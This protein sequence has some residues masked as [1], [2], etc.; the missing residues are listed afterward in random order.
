MSANYIVNN[1]RLRNLLERRNFSAVAGTVFTA[2]WS[3]IS[4]NPPSLQCLLFCDRGNHKSIRQQLQNN[5]P[6]ILYCDGVRTFYLLKH[7]ARLRGRMRIV[8]DLDDLMSRRMH[9][10]GAAKK[11]SLSLGYLHDKVP[12]WLSNVLALGTVSKVIACYEQAALARVEK[13]IG[14]WS[15]AVVLISQVEGNALEERYRRL[16]CKARVHVVPPPKEIIAPPQSYPNISRFFFIGTDALPQNKVTIE[17]ILD[18]W[19][20]I[21]PSTEIRRIFGRMVSNWPAIP[22]V[23]F[24]GY[25][26]SLQDVYVEGAVLFAPG[27]LRGGL[28]TKVVEAFAHGCAVI[29]NEIT[30]EGMHLTKYPLFINTRE[31][32]IQ[33]TKCPSSYLHQMREAAV[34]GQ[35]YVRIV[36]SQK[37]F[38]ENWNEVLG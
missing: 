27:G 1:L 21:A 36:F 10:L 18:L 17:L 35:D 4:G 7:I 14:Q 34:L 9:S 37:H 11:T 12:S 33:L 13:L 2:L 31:E 25:A 38:E 8:V 28:K 26:P 15:D 6:D 5:P 29:G 22:G 3:T 23:V 19:R 24:R 16:G 30:F 32:M 20:S